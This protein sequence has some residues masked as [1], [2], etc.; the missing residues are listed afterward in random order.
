MEQAAGEQ[1]PLVTAVKAKARRPVRKRTI[2]EGLGVDKR[3]FCGRDTEFLR[4]PEGNRWLTLGKLQI[5]QAIAG[6]ISDNGNLFS[7][8]NPL[9]LEMPTTMRAV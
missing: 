8:P 2:K 3:R 4:A 6:R 7:I 5:T 9:K 1:P